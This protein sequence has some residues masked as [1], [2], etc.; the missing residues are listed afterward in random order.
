VYSSLEPLIDWDEVLSQMAV[1]VF[2]GHWDGYAPTRNNYFVHLDDDGRLRMMPWGVDQTFDYGL[3]LYEGQGLILQRCLADSVCRGAWEQKLLAVADNAE[4]LV[5]GGFDTE[6][7]GLAADLVDVFADDP[8]REWD[9]NNIPFLADNALNFINARIQQVRDELGCTLDPDADTDDDG[10]SCSLDCNEGDPTIHFNGTEVCGNSI[11]EDCSGR[12]D[13][14]PSCPD[15][16]LEED[17]GV[18][19]LLFCSAPRSYADAE[20]ACADAGMRLVSILDENDNASIIDRGFQRF[21]DQ[22][23]WIGLDDRDREGVYRWSD[24]RS[25]RVGDNRPFDAF[26]G[27]EPNDFGAGEDCI[28]TTGDQ[29]NDNSCDAGFVVVC[30]PN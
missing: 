25:W 27:G 12:L 5:A 15:C 23:F 10:Y 20:A 19:P 29:W 17:D 3:P 22:A 16:V 8:R 1:E 9:H 14:D 11:D 18:R 2:I 6:I 28:H 30:E 4:A 7:R 24:G 13:D 26:A 21:G